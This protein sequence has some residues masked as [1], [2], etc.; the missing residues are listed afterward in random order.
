M[1]KSTGMT[2]AAAVILSVAV[3][4]SGS[5]MSLLAETAPASGQEVV[6]TEASADVQEAGET[7]AE[8]ADA[9]V[10]PEEAVASD[11]EQTDD[12]QAEKGQGEDAASEDTSEKESEEITL[13]TPKLTDLGDA[14]AQEGES[15]GII[16]DS[17]ESESAEAESEAPDTAEASEEAVPEQITEATAETAGE[18]A[19]QSN[20]AADLIPVSDDEIVEPQEKSDNEK[21]KLGLFVTDENLLKALT[22][23]YNTKYPEDKQTTTGITI[24]H[25]WKL[26]KVIL[27]GANTGVVPSEIKSIA[28]LGYAI[29]ATEIDFSETGA[30]QIPNDEFYGLTKLETVVMNDNLAGIGKNAFQGCSSLVNVH[31]R[32]GDAIVEDGEG[33]PINALPSNLQNKGTGS[34]SF[35][36][37]TALESIRLPELGANNGAALQD[38]VAMFQGCVKLS[39]VEI[40]AG[41]RI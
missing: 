17:T 3:T 11:G 31:L 29:G 22:N 14:K 30:T 26:D 5:G 15:A 19:E 39:K 13:T 23:L 35:S 27:S 38:A 20:A 8:S 1:R 34:R 12:A 32:K 10:E 37:C 21:D 2:R 25:I 33:N 28:G 16:A 41:V 18:A 9:Q 24:G 4:M 7:E 36:G 6:L 40:P